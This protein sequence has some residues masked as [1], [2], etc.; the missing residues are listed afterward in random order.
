MQCRIPKIPIGSVFESA[1]GIALL[2]E[3]FI[4]HSKFEVDFSTISN[5]AA[6]QL[7]CAISALYSLAVLSAVIVKF[8]KPIVQHRGVRLI[9]FRPCQ[10]LLSLSEALFVKS[11]YTLLDHFLRCPLYVS[12]NP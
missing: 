4:S 10:I 7:Q 2:F 6:L 3:A 8:S 12:C 5:T 1:A 9:L 11:L